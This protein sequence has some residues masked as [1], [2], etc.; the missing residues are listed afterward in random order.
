MLEPKENSAVTPNKNSNDSSLKSK[1]YSELEPKTP[2]SVLN[3]SKS[4]S[5]INT[6]NENGW[7]PI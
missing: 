7:T 1:A 3:F 4:I 2:S 5:E 6:Q